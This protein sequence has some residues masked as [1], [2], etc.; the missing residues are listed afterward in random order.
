M[1]KTPKNP[2]L[3]LAKSSRSAFEKRFEEIYLKAA[4]SGISDE[5]LIK[6]VND[7]DA[8]NQSSQSGQEQKGIQDEENN[9][10]TDKAGSGEKP[11]EGL[12]LINKNELT[13]EQMEA[14]PKVYEDLFGN[15]IPD[16]MSME[17]VIELILQKQTENSQS[18][19]QNSSS[20]T[21]DEIAEIQNNYFDLFGTKPLESMTIEQVLNSI[22]VKQSELDKAEKPKVVAENPVELKE[23][24][25]YAINSV[26]EKVVINKGTLKFLPDFK[27]F[28]QVPKE[29]KSK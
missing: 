14:L 5:V 21:E 18:P 6:A 22:E 10:G 16:G 23:G 3:P 4:E 17:D 8:S 12:E 7:H 28:V 27:E 29:L 1:T 24:Q 11:V 19:V 20:M 9:P 26:G 15:K 2:Q 13:F 25:I